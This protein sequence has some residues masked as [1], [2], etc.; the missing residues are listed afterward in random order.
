MT[1]REILEQLKA[2]TINAEEAMKR[3]EELEKKEDVAA[4]SRAVSEDLP[5]RPY[6]KPKWLVVRIKDKEGERVNIRV[7]LALAKLTKKLNVGNQKVDE[8]NVDEILKF[9]EDNGSG[10]FVDIQ[11]KDGDT[12]EV[13]VE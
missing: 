8:I 9:A 6:K 12:I 13:F 2:G 3:L 10:K 5:H 11:S 1:K 7:P 4:E